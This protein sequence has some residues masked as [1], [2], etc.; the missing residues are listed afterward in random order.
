MRC[1]LKRSLDRRLE[2]LA[3]GI[4]ARF[5]DFRRDSRLARQRKAAG[6]S[7]IGKHER[8][9]SG[10][11]GR[12]RRLDQRRHVG[13]AP[14]NENGDPR[15]PRSQLQPPAHDDA[16]ALARREPADRRRLEAV[17]GKRAH[18]LVRRLRR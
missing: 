16:L 7:L 6:V 14:G 12:A 4:G 13:A 11:I 8:D 5:D 15:P 9:L 3:G 17:G 18:R 1:A 2:R 10:K